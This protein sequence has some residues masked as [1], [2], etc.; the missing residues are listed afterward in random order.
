[1][2]GTI[3]FTDGA[4]SGNPGPGGWGAIIVD[5]DSGKVTEIGGAEKGTTNN[6]MEMIAAIEAIS[7]ISSGT[8]ISSITV[9]TDSGYL[10]SGATKWIFGWM[11]NGWKTSTKEDVINRDL[12]LKIAELS[13]KI[14]VEWKQIGGHIGVIGNERCDEIATSFAMGND[15]NL[16]SGPLTDYPVKNILDVSHDVS[17]LKQKKSS[18]SKSV[19]TAYSYVSMVNGK[20][21]IHKTW[22]ECEAR[23]K[24]AKGAKYK[25]SQSLSDEKNI[26]HEFLEG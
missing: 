4:S 8:K 2:K 26:I 22:E 15:I 24:G 21:E 14:K 13:K 11:K 19:K 20:I 12:W 17:L 6:R 16:Y 1:M 9:F 7:Q 23:V 3:I 18:N 25:K 10:V 5:T